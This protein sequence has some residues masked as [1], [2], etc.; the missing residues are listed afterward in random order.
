[1]NYETFILSAERIDVN[2]L[3]KSALVSLVYRPDP[4]TVFCSFGSAIYCLGTL[5]RL[6]MDDLVKKTSTTWFMA[7]KSSWVESFLNVSTVITVMSDL[8][9]PLINMK[10][11][12]PHLPSRDS[13][14]ILCIRKKV[15]EVT[16]GQR[17]EWNEVHRLSPC[18]AFNPG[19]NL[20][21]MLIALTSRT[22]SATVTGDRSMSRWGNITIENG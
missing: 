6:Q 11:G 20:V 22:I 15:F 8:S 14:Y 13:D 12:R 17:T 21:S 3:R 16:Q 9:S 19:T 2:I 4:W 7:N 10:S 1:M 18:Q 5:L